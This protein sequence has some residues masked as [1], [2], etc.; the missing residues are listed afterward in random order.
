ADGEV[1]IWKKELSGGAFAIGVFNRGAGDATVT[2][3]C[4]DVQLCGGYKMRDLWAQADRGVLGDTATVSVA[5]HGVALL[6][7]SR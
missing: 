2:L 1:E 6:R 4:A 3:R 5:T 7:L